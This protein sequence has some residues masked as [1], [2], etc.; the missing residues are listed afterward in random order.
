MRIFGPLLKLVFSSFF[1]FFFFFFLLL[2]L[3]LCPS[4]YLSLNR[5]LSSSS[6]SLSL[7]VTPLSSPLA[8]HSMRGQTD[9]D[10]EHF[11]RTG[12]TKVRVSVGAG[13]LARRDGSTRGRK[14]HLSAHASSYPFGTSCPVSP[15]TSDPSSNFHVLMCTRILLILC[16]N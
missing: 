4:V 5:S 2:H 9:R 11:R 3:S 15:A 8:Q 7:F 14:S 10:K 6:L 12:E 13:I 1:F 16:C